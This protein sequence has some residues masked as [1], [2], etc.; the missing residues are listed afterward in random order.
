M[1]HTVERS[2]EDTREYFRRVT[3]KTVPFIYIGHDIW[4]GKNKSIL[5]LCL[6]LASPLLKEL[7]V[8]PVAMLRNRGKDAQAIA[9]QSHKALQR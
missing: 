9:D 8:I 1:V 7:L 5:G 3:K 2:V 4:D 6:F